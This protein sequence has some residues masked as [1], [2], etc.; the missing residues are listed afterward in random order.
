MDLSTIYSDKKNDD[1]AITA[2]KDSKHVNNAYANSDVLRSTMTS[3]YSTTRITT[4]PKGTGKH[5][6]DRP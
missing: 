1:N 5:P 4:R 3:S 2:S 6:N